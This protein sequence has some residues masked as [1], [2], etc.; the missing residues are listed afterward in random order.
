MAKNN[1]DLLRLVEFLQCS[2]GRT[3]AEIGE[4]F[5]VSIRSVQRRLNAIAIELPGIEISEKMDGR[6]KRLRCEPPVTF[7]QAT[8]KATE[9]LLLRRLHIAAQALRDIGM[10][11]DANGIEDFVQS[12][13]RD[14]PQAVRQRCDRDLKRLADHE[15]LASA[16]PKVVAK[17]GV[18]E[19]VRLAMLTD[20]S[21]IIRRRTGGEVHGKPIQMSH[22]LSGSAILRVQSR[23][24]EIQ[25][26]QLEDITEVKGVDDVL[27]MQLAA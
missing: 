5:C 22:G 25:D 2:Q 18:M 8:L 9:I 6:C 27:V 24:H 23:Q 10:A 12:L 14:M 11:D 4:K 26:I 17:N 21:V 3:F 15:H 13:M 16:T 7:P 19:R 20:R 1:M